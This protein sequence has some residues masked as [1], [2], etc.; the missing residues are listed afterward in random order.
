MTNKN[1]LFEKYKQGEDLALNELLD[2]EREGFYDY[3]IRMTGQIS[4]ALETTEDIFR[5][6]LDA[7]LTASNYSE[8]RCEFFRTGRNF[9][10]D[11]WKSDTSTL[12]NPALSGIDGTERERFEL[13]DQS[14]NN[15]PSA[16]KECIVLHIMCA[17]SV[18]ETAS[19]MGNSVDETNSNLVEALQNINENC[20]ESSK[21]SEEDIRTLTKHLPPLTSMNATIDLGQVVK[22][23]KNQSIGGK[24]KKFIILSL[25]AAGILIYLYPSEF[26]ILLDQL[27]GTLENEQLK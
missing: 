12:K 15:L 9:N 16:L 25:L 24:V 5:S 2:T 6:L 14:I 27:L 13:I 23:M 20:S 11:L 17:F 18:E 4:R 22:G 3:L 8:F 10:A 21:T 26:R 1:N 7:P 19:I